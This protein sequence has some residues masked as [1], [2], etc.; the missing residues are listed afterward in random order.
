[1]L[2]LGIV[3]YAD[4]TYADMAGFVIRLLRNRARRHLY[5]FRSFAIA[6]LF[7]RAALG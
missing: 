1:M 4:I 3:T 2:G 5:F 6:A 7:G